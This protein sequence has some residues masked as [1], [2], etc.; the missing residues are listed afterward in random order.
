M[1]LKC[2]S[3]TIERHGETRIECFGVQLKMHL[4]W[5]HWGVPVS[6]GPTAVSVAF[7]SHQD[8]QHIYLY[9]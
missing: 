4:V 1:A 5:S 2:F 8:V 3:I 6:D 7:L 9:L